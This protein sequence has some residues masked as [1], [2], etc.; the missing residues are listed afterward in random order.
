MLNQSN[1][2]QS[3]FTP[4]ASQPTATAPH[5]NTQPNK[6]NEDVQ[7]QPLHPYHDADIAAT[8][9]LM[10]FSEYCKLRDVWAAKP[11][12]RGRYEGLCGGDPTQR[13]RREDFE[14]ISL[15]T[16]S[17]SS[18]ASS[19]APAIAAQVEPYSRSAAGKIIDPHFQR[20]PLA[21]E[22]TMHF[23][24]EHYLRCPHTPLVYSEPF[25]IWGYLWDRL[26]G[27][28]TTWAPQLPPSNVSLKGYVDSESGRQLST[29]GLHRESVRRVRWLEFTAAALAVGGAYLCLT[30]KGCQ[31]FMQDKKQFLE[32]MSQCF[33]DLTV[34]YRA[35]QRQRNAEF[36]SVLL[37]LYG[38]NQEMKVEDRATFCRFHKVHVNGEERLC[39]ESPAESV[40]LAQV[41]REL[42]RQPYM[43]NTQP[44][45]AALELIYCWSTRRWFDFFALC[46][47]LKLTPLQRA[48]GFQSFT[49][50]RYRAVL[51]LVLPNLYVYPNLR[52][53]SAVV[54]DELAS[55]LMME[56]AHCLLFLKAMGLADQLELKLP[57]PVAEGNVA[58]ASAPQQQQTAVWH[59]NLCH[60]NSEPLVTAEELED[61]CRSKH[62]LFFPT[63][64]EFFGFRV[65]HDAYAR[66]PNAPGL[67]RA[68]AAAASAS[69]AQKNDG[70]AAAAGVTAGRSDASPAGR[71]ATR[72]RS[73]PSSESPRSGNDQYGAEGEGEEDYADEDDERSRSASG[74]YDN[75]SDDD[76]YYKYEEEDEEGEERSTNGTPPPSAATHTAPPSPFST[77]APPATAAAATPEAELLRCSGCPVNLMEVLEVYCPPYNADVRELKL[78]DASPAL[79][80]QLQSHR[81]AMLRRCRRVRRQS[82]NWQDARAG[83][84]PDDNATAMNEREEAWVE[85]KE[86]ESAS[87]CSSVVNSEFESEGEEEGNVDDEAYERA[88]A[89]LRQLQGRSAD[90]HS[91]SSVVGSSDAYVEAARA[92]SATDDAS[93]VDA[94]V[95]AV[96]AAAD[97]L[98]GAVSSN[99]LYAAAAADKA[100]QQHQEAEG[101]AAEAAAASTSSAP[102]PPPLPHI[103]RLSL[104]L[105]GVCT[106]EPL[107]DSY[108]NAEGGGADTDSANNSSSN[109]N[110]D[111][112]NAQ[113]SHVTVESPASVTI[114]GGGGNNA[115]GFRASGSEVR[116]DSAETVEPQP[117]ATT[118]SSSSSLFPGRPG[119]PSFVFGAAK[120]AVPPVRFNTTM[121][122]AP[123]GVSASASVASAAAAA[124]AVGADAS[125]TPTTASRGAARHDDSDSN[126]R[127]TSSAP[128]LEYSHL[129]RRSRVHANH[130]GGSNNSNSSSDVEECDVQSG[131]TSDGGTSQSMS[132]THTNHEVD[133]PPH[134][135]ATAPQRAA[136]PAP[137]SPP[138]SAEIV[139]QSFTPRDAM[140]TRRRRRR[141][142]S[143]E[144]RDAAGSSSSS[145]EAGVAEDERERLLKRQ[146]VD[147][148]ADAHRY[149]PLSLYL[150]PSEVNVFAD[151]CVPL[152]EE[153]LELWTQLTEGDQAALLTAADC[154]LRARASSSVTAA[155]VQKLARTLARRARELLTTTVLRG[156]MSEYGLLLW[157]T[158]AHA[159]TTSADSLDSSSLLLGELWTTS[160]VSSDTSLLMSQCRRSALHADSAEVWAAR[161]NRG[162][163]A[164]RIARYEVETMMAV[165]SG[166]VPV[167]L[168]AQA[169][170]RTHASTAAPS[171]LSASR[172]MSAAQPHALGSVRGRRALSVAL[173]AAL[174]TTIG[175]GGLVGTQSSSHG[176]VHADAVAKAIAT[177]MDAATDAAAAA[178]A[179]TTAF[180]GDD[181]NDSGSGGDDPSVVFDASIGQYVTWT[182][183]RAA[184]SAPPPSEA[185]VLQLTSTF[186]LIS[187][188]WHAHASSC[189]DSEGDTLQQQQYALETLF[190]KAKE[191]WL[192]QLL[193]PSPVL[194][195]AAEEERSNG[196]DAALPYASQYNSRMLCLKQP[197]SADATGGPVLR[198]YQRDNLTHIPVNAST[199]SV[200]YKTHGGTRSRVQCSVPLATRVG[201]YACDART[202]L[203]LRVRRDGGVRLDAEGNEDCTALPHTMTTTPAMAHAHYTAVVA[204][205]VADAAAIIATRRT[206]I[207]IVESHVTDV[208]GEGGTVTMNS[209][210]GVLLCLLSSPGSDDGDDDD[211]GVS[212][213]TQTAAELEEFFWQRWERQHGAVEQS[214]SS[215]PAVVAVHL[216]YGDAAAASAAVARGMR[217]VMAT[218]AQQAAAVLAEA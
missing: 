112:C 59:L 90:H 129:K 94:S 61:R 169:S 153:Y 154:V 174:N 77:T 66:F 115:R 6:H 146:K 176:G 110:E 86:A 151:V 187:S 31:R 204:V 93:G 21:L 209:V 201:L 155:R 80:A 82:R 138:P 28:R 205:D 46:K 130:D 147:V 191:R 132:S 128:M 26:R 69:H 203:R 53:R 135:A 137:A 150:A 198:L 211:D 160:T 81:S 44:V 18:P 87:T 181:S 2:M 96:I 142:G 24:V 11:L 116:E 105:T 16:S 56:P 79:F 43:L 55:Q 213:P 49:Y 41:N 195:D 95:L 63:Y 97:K 34:F 192:A 159:S 145:S 136:S 216:P 161:F 45:R 1:T 47:S 60:R 52:V 91:T 83:A 214:T 123:T 172:Q 184:A 168:P 89:V 71:G 117:P 42:E 186:V 8:L 48:V 40:N 215:A 177:T 108:G 148:A 29:S 200:S 76:S 23:L 113:N 118:S 33:T 78:V 202:L 166:T 4:H 196:D 152:V 30:P 131:N 208:S 36:F 67:A 7:Q 122:T 88:Q 173:A 58:P 102:P 197:T 206:L 13:E 218:Y 183:S 162:C 188:E 27:I 73:R 125:T 25:R 141:S 51:D 164:A 133:L 114:S 127:S 170:R 17:S 157:D 124:A 85:A 99:T 32:S 179:A 189:V 111:R 22:K 100:A 68:G 35:E 74:A 163:S 62:A 14:N 217:T 167:L 185:A 57:A 180:A 119:Q 9:S 70:A 12:V 107:P 175:N 171:A 19:Y 121:P 101:K 193:L 212:T 178:A 3:S 98:V 143:D 106:V 126:S 72:M 140:P 134:A 5:A 210:A 75:N 120:A 144:S 194:L 10:P 20:T 38:L 149:A 84:A 50:A 15:R 104:P 182:P 158:A 190:Y 109:N 207:S 37:L 65:W 156:S 39:P 92:P 139:S 199:S 103:P 64:P 54:V 165:E